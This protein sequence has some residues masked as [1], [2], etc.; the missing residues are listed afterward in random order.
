MTLKS[1]A[2]EADVKLDPGGTPTDFSEGEWAATKTVRT[3]QHLKTDGSPVAWEA[4]GSFVFTGPRKDSGATASTPPVLV[5][6]TGTSE[7]TFAG[8]PVLRDGDENSESVF[9]NRVY[10]EATRTLKSD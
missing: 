4:T 1:V 7:A 10:V 9:G 3:Y 5:T 8:E 2:V 6:L